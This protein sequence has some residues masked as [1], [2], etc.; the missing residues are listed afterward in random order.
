MILSAEIWVLKRKKKRLAWRSVLLTNCI[1]V[2]IDANNSVVVDP[3]QHSNDFIEFLVC[4][5]NNALWCDYSNGIFK[6]HF[7]VKRD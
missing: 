4:I 7:D 3:L 1:K 5:S 6:R 2:I